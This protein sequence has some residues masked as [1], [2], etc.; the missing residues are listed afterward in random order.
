MPAPSPTPRR[1]R[2]LE[3]H[4]APGVQRCHLSARAAGLWSHTRGCPEGGPAPALHCRPRGRGRCSARTKLPQLPEHRWRDPEAAARTCLLF[5]GD[6]GGDEG[7]GAAGL[8]VLD[9]P[10]AYFSPARGSASPM[11]SVVNAAAPVEAGAHRRGFIGPS[12]QDGR[13]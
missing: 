8:Q 2:C 3:E 9:P 1:V 5:L 11:P 4:V 12:F 7:Q 6:C 13:H 10:A